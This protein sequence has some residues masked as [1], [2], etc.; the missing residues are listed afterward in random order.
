MLNHVNNMQH[1]TASPKFLFQSQQNGYSLVVQSVLGM[2]SL[3]LVTRASSFTTYC[4]ALPQLL[5][6]PCFRTSCRQDRGFCAPVGIRIS[7]CSLQRTYLHQRDQNSGVKPPHRHQLFF[8]ACNELCGCCPQQ[9]APNDPNTTGNKR[10][11]EGKILV[12]YPVVIRE[13]SPSNCWEQMH[14]PTVIHYT[15]REL[16]GF[17]DSRIMQ[18]TESNGRDYYLFT[19]TGEAS[20]VPALVCT[21]SSVQIL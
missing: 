10:K 18:R 14:R 6:Y 19:E 11:K 20:T 13:A 3:S 9:G 15:E 4:W 5:C 1:A 16:R 17:K 8:S 21:R 12:P 7:F 2:V